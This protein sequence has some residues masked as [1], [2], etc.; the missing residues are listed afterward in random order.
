MCFAHMVDFRI[1]RRHCISWITFYANTPMGF[2]SLFNDRDEKMYII[3]FAK[4][5][6]CFVL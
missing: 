6:H 3:R 5:R 2:M 1:D 4:S